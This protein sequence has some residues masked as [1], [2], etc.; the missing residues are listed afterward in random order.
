MFTSLVIAGGANK[1]FCS[2]GCIRYLE[3][4]NELA[5]ILHFVGTSAGAIVCLMLALGYTSHEMEACILEVVQD[6][7]GQFDASEVLYLLDTYGLNSGANILALGEHIIHRKTGRKEITF[8]ELAKTFGKNLVMCGAN[9]TDEREEFFCVDTHPEMNVA[10][11][12]RISCSI[13]IL[14]APYRWKGKLYID[15]GFYNNFPINYF[16]DHSMRDILGINIH[17]TNY[18]RDETFLEYVMLLVNAIFNKANHKPLDDLSRNIVTIALEDTEWF[19]LSK[20]KVVITPE[21]M[22]HWITL[23]YDTIKDKFTV[24]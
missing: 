9:L 23:G 21:Q 18:R 19:S 4:H 12:L 5:S 24:T 15:G 10:T 6:D 22:T 3:E 1:V 11:A 20:M 8:M 13:P 7:L 2:I 16:K 14:F 17:N